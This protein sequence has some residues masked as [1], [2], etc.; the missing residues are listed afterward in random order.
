VSTKERWT[1]V[2]AVLAAAVAVLPP[3]ASAVPI[4]TRV[5]VGTDEAEARRGGYTYSSGSSITPDG[6]FVVFVSGSRALVRDDGGDLDAFVRDRRRDTTTLITVRDHRWATDPDPRTDGGQEFSMSSDGRYI[7]FR[8]WDDDLVRGD[9][10]GAYD[11][12]VRDIR[13]RTTTRLLRADGDE[14][15][16]GTFSPS[17]S[18]NGRY[19]GFVSRS[20]HLVAGDTNGKFDVFVRDRRRGTTRLISRG[21]DGR[22]A[23]NDSYMTA[24]SANGR[25][26]AYTSP[27]SNIAR[28]DTNRRVDVFVYDRV[29]G[30]TVWSTV[31]STGGQAGL[32]HHRGADGP[33]ISANGRFVAF[34]S[35]AANFVQGDSNGRRDIFVRDLR[36]GTTQRVSVA[37]GGRQVCVGRLAYRGATCHLGGTISPDGRFLAFTS[38]APDLVPGDTNQVDDVFVHDT[39]TLITTRASVT[40]SG[41]EI[42]LGRRDEVCSD[43]P[44]LSAGGRFVVFNS[45]AADVVAGDT[46]SARDVFVRG[47]FD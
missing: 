27:A 38:A 8:S 25:Y 17:I 39:R 22:P 15:D 14:I 1:A 7:A 29:A 33:S 37:S 5:S 3:I 31:G 41:G 13:R 18:R 24:I 10:N 32:I 4:T 26:I 30:K 43:A 21:F 46:N 12:F 35:N 23:K 40:A 36:G 42:C 45:F 19:L 6:R 2:A 20:A 34:A 47:P 44:S 16:L 11:I 9:T 28:R